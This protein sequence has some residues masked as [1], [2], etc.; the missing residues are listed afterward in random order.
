[1]RRNRDRLVLLGI[2]L[3]LTVGVTSVAAA[4]V[5]PP[6]PPVAGS[7]AAA[8]R[9]N[10]LLVN[11]DDATE[12]MLDWRKPDGSLVM[13]NV[14]SFKSTA[15]VYSNTFV[16][17][18]SCCPSRFSLFT[19]RYPHNTGGRLQEDGTALPVNET[20]AHQLKAAGYATAMA[21]KFLV[22]WPLATPPPSYDRYS[23]IKGG[24]Y[25]PRI[26]RNGVVANVSGYS[27]NLLANDLR[28]YLNAFEATNDSQPW[29]GYWAPQTPHIA[30]GWKTLAVPETQYANVD[31]GTCAQPVET[32]RTDKPPYVGAVPIDT[33]YDQAVCASQLRAMVTVD[34]RFGEMLT[35]LRN[36][37]E[38]DTTTIVLTSDNGYHWGEQGWFSKFYPYEASIGVPLY[39]KWPAAQ[40]IAP[41]TDPRLTTSLDITAT[42]FALTGAVPVK[43]LDGRSL[44]AT[45]TRQEAFVEYFNDVSNGKAIPTWALLRGPTWK[46]VETTVRNATT[47]VV[48]L[49]KEYYN[50]TADP[51]ELTNVLKDGVAGN[52][53]SKAVLNGLAARLAAARTCAGI[54]CP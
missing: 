3:L 47:G 48:T 44:L 33:A 53:P 16:D 14:R 52:E 7:V 1:V 38:Y 22:P 21:G 24:Y 12:K 43:P 35:Q 37:G 2:S 41:R 8:V 11:L 34:R 5:V 27:T 36:R 30:G 40:A 39:V 19:G 13:P 32:N 42:L 9:P 31:V 4:V 49:Y 6:A 18:P 45:T 50:L 17:I 15:T 10:V 26:N 46:Y 28:G 25:N 51:G 20:L 29:F 23:F 54:T